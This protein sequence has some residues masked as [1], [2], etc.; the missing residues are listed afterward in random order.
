VLL[1]VSEVVVPVDQRASILPASQPL[2][3]PL[4]GVGALDDAR[5]HRLVEFVVRQPLE[6]WPV[7]LQRRGSRRTG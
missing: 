6:L 2:A 4:A 5:V 3:T 7:A 1:G